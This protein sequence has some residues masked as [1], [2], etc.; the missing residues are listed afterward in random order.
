M[1]SKFSAI[2]FG[3]VPPARA[4]PR[5]FITSGERIPA[6]LIRV[7]RARKCLQCLTLMLSLGSRLIKRLLLLIL[8]IRLNVRCSGHCYHTVCVRIHYNSL[9]PCSLHIGKLMIFIVSCSADFASSK[10]YFP[11]DKLLCQPQLVL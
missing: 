2:L 8:Q 1:C 11:S 6:P 3:T 4:A 7:R 9:L 10:H 5:H